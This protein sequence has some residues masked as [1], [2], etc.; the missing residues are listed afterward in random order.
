MINGVN[1]DLF[2]IT[3]ST[4][5]NARR[6]VRPGT[7]LLRSVSSLTYTFAN[8]AGQT[9]RTFTCGRAD[10]SIYDVQE[11]SPRTVEDSVPG[12]APWFSGYAPDGSELPD[13]R[14]TL[15]IEGTTEGPSPSTQQISYGLTL[16]TKA[17]VISNVTVSGDGNER[18]LSFD[19]ADSSPISAVG[20]SA[21]ADGPI[22]ERG[23]EALPAPNAGRMGWFTA[24]STLR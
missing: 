23:A 4:D 14:Y 1:P 2:I 19:V 6:G 20:F 3:R 11:R 9:I 7:V 24:T 22:V 17:P 16:D 5:E 12:C 10:R 15:T 21:T 8:E 18:T 13:G